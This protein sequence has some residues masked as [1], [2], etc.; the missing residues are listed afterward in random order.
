M[1]IICTWS[2]FFHL[3]LSCLPQKPVDLLESTSGP[4]PVTVYHVVQIKDNLVS[5]AMHLSLQMG[6]HQRKRQAPH[7][8]PSH[9][10]SR[11]TYLVLGF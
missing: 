7:A 4:T 11:W 3:S 2:V 9:Q 1:H 6:P 10:Q 5:E 8:Q